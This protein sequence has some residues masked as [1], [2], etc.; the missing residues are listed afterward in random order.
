MIVF[1]A[2]DGAIVNY[3]TLGIVVSISMFIAMI[4]MGRVHRLLLKNTN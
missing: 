2:E 1:K 4:L 3:P